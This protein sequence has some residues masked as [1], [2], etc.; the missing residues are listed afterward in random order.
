MAIVASTERLADQDL[1]EAAL[2]RGVLLEVLA[3]FVE[4][5]RADAV[6]LAARQGGL[7]H[8][9]GVDRALGLAGAD[10]GVDLVDEDD[11]LALVLRHFLEHAL[12]PLLE[13]AAEL[14]AGEQQRHV[15]DEHALVLEACRAPRR[16]RCAGPGPR[17]SPSCRRPARRSA[18]GCSWSAAA[19]PGWRGGSRRRG[20]SPGRACR[21]GRARSG[22]GCTSSAPRAGP[23]PRRCRPSGRR[24][25]LRSP[26]RAPCRVTPFCFSS[27][28]IDALRVGGGEDE[29]L[30]GD[31]LV[32]ALVGFLS[33]PPAAG[34]VSSRPGCT[35]SP[36]CTCG[37]LAISA[38][39]AVCSRATLAP[40][41]ESSA[42]GPSGWASIADSRCA[43]STY[44]LLLVTAR[45]CASASASGTWS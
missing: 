5:G 37:S 1:L 33:R 39:S 18:P 24:A 2:E 42:F 17:R 4:R 41:R 9:A 30:A 34:C 28:P 6:Q 45:L 10:H 36:P 23:R 15:E 8:V 21:R 40:A 3:V 29:H 25:P 12:Q 14:G 44:G 35:A 43:G 7:E 32:A 13:L 22:R 27:V 11:G 16:R 31:E 20:R 38:S 19:A 26:S